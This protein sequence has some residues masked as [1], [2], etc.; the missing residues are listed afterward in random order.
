MRP[1]PGS[2][3]VAFA[4]IAI[5][6]LTLVLVGC[7]SREPSTLVTSQVQRITPRGQAW[8]HVSGIAW[9]PDSTQ[10][11][12][13]WTYGGSDLVP[14]SY[15]FIIE[16][17]GRNPTRLIWTD[18]DGYSQSPT[19]SP[20]SSQ[21]AFY[22]DGWD[23]AGIW[24]A[25]TESA[26]AP[27]FLA[28]GYS[29]A[30][31]PDGTQIAIANPAGRTYA[32]EIVNVLTGEYRQV[33]HASSDESLAAGYGISWSLTGDRLAFSYGWNVG[34]MDIYEIN[35]T[36]NEFRQITQGGSNIFPSYSPDGTRIAFA[37]GET[38]YDTTL[39]VMNIADGSVVR[40]I[41]AT[42]VNAVAWAPNG[43]AIAFEWRGGVYTISTVFLGGQDG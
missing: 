5:V 25:D 14:E 21:V 31:S 23:P 20:V 6:A 15:L 10:L 3:L 7:R 12:L 16:A 32:V 18:A 19:W 36:T 13:S 27:V 24:L 26:G 11:A 39:V 35:L 43:S 41:E 34:G 40:P 29:C 28:E 22:S 9:S 1:Q 37:G 4:R 8:N 42:P 38:L 30:W 33:F 17:S 2:T